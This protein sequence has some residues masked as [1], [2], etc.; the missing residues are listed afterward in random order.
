MSHS[1]T[2]VFYTLVA[3][4][5]FAVLGVSYKIGERKKCDT[6]QVNFFLFFTAAV[7]LCIW[8]LAGHTSWASPKL[9]GMGVFMAVMAV[10]CMTAFRASITKGRV[11]TTWTIT[12]L[13]LIIPTIGAI[14]FFNEKPTMFH[15]VGFVLIFLSIIFL[16]IDIARS[17]E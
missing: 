3:L 5:S 6:R 17:G 2:G 9:L 7:I 8:M 16:G 13:S 12:S 10:G 11:S 4:V 15:M 1:I 14:L